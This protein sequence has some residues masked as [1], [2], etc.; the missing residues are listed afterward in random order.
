MNLQQMKYVVYTA[1]YYSISK[2]AR[3]LF[4]TQPNLSSA[5]KDLENELGIQIF[6]RNKKGVSLTK[7]GAELVSHIQPILKQIEQIE[8]NYKKKEE[9]DY[10]LSIACQHSNFGGEGLLKLLQE[11]DEDAS[12][13]V[14]FLELR[15]KELLEYVQHG[16]CDMG[17]LLRNR[18]NKVLEWEIEKRDLE[19]HLLKT[20][21]PHVF[22][23]NTHP[24][25]GSKLISEED[26]KPYPYVKYSQG[27]DS[28]RF[29]SED[30][31][32]NDSAKKVITVTD[33][34]SDMLFSRNLNAYTLGTG[35]R[36]EHFSSR[37]GVSIPYDSTE[38][39]E[40]G[41]I[42]LKGM[43]RSQ[44]CEKYIKMITKIANNK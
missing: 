39:I 5:I 15:T 22:L 16:I 31:I 3:A 11:L 17:I 9:A 19:F 4:V 43:E 42:A 21:K 12:Y 25:A 2:A 6:D 20:L 41:W 13:D 44:L 36:T 7:A 8:E 1:Q 18:D 28:N 29:F 24:L 10:T 34:M 33:K 14:Q 32:E 26:L 40:I 30:L 35:M 37:N 38:K 27:L 23:Q